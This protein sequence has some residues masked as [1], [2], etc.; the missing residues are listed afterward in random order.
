[1]LQLINCT[2]TMMS[3]GCYSHL[4]TPDALDAVYS[5]IMY[6]PCCVGTLSNRRDSGLLA[7]GRGGAKWY[8]LDTWVSFCLNS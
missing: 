7:F 8:I 2:W 3:M 4:S 5:C 6:K 1:M